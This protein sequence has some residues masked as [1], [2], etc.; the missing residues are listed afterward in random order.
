[1]KVFNEMGK[2]QEI[3][4]DEDSSFMCV[5]LHNWLNSKRVQVQLTTSKS[6]ILDIERFHKT[7]NENLRITPVYK[8]KIDEIRLQGNNC[9]PVRYI[10]LIKCCTTNFKCKTS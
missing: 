2:P 3:K 1:M 6:G 5:A 9:F 10:S 8:K 4:A 7:I